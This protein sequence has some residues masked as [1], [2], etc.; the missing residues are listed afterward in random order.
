MA[1]GLYM[2]AEG[3][4]AQSRRMEVIANNLANVDTVGFKRQLAVFQA[5]Y[6]EA[7]QQGH[8]QA[9]GGSIDDIGG[10]IELLST[11]TDFSQGTLHRTGVNSDMALRG[12]GFFLVRRGSEDFLTRAGNFRITDRGELVTQHGDAVLTEGGSPVV[13]AQ[14]NQP[15][16]VNPDGSIQQGGDQQRLAIVKTGSPAELERVGENLFRPLGEHT[17][18][19]AAERQVAGGFLEASGSTAVNEMVEMIETSRILEAN[20]NLMQTQDQMFGNLVTRLTRVS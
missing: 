9:G 2:S 18:V 17:P 8:S 6:S 3:A 10:G 4:Q 13:I 5:R 16:T 20:M 12:D 15:F 11:D 7:E 1:Y 14:P 19:S